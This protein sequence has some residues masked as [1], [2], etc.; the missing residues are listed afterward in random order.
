MVVEHCF[1][2]KLGNDHEER[3]RASKEAPHDSPEVIQ[4]ATKGPERCAGNQYEEDSTAKVFRWIPN[5]RKAKKHRVEAAKEARTR[6]NS[7]MSKGTPTP[8][9]DDKPGFFLLRFKIRN[10]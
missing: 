5:D 9:V 7:S 3:L 6:R 2:V 1:F 8:E 4:G 10:Y